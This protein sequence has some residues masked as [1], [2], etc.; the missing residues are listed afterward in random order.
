MQDEVTYP[1]TR[2]A[3]RFKLIFRSVD[4]DS[5]STSETKKTRSHF[6]LEIAKKNRFEKGIFLDFLRKFHFLLKHHENYE[7]NDGKK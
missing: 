6:F 5:E 3:S 4:S 7:Q 2:D 1:S